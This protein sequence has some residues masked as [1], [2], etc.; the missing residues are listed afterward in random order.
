MVST[1]TVAAAMGAGQYA[2]PLEDACIQF[3]IVTALQKSHFLAQVAHESDGFRRATEYASGRAYEG[4]ADLGNVQPGDGVRFKGRGLIQLTGRENYATFS[5]AMGQGSLLVKFPEQVA[6]LPWSVLAAG[7]F[8]QRRGLNALA[9]RDDA[10]GVTKRI[11]G[12]RNGLED[13]LRRLSQAK[14]LFGI[15]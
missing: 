4:R 1:E 12:G 5:N 2:K 6:Q 8:W 11:N 3:G 13:R 7:W 14:K 10:V 9:D 15:I